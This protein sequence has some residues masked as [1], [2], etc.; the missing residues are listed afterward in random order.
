[1]ILKSNAKEVASIAQETGAEIMRGRVQSF[2]QLTRDEGGSKW[3]V[4]QVRRC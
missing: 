3:L 4:G 2:K 1:M